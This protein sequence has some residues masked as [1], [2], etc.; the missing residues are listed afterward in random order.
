MK[1]TLGILALF[2]ALAAP[3][4]ALAQASGNPAYTYLDGRI[5]QYDPEGPGS[6][7]GIRIG[8]SY[9]F[10]QN[11]F[12][13]GSYT[14]VSDNG[15]DLSLLEFGAGMRSPLSSTM[16]LVGSAAVVL[17]D[18]DVD[19]DTGISLTGGVRAM[20]GPQFEVGGYAN[21]TEIFS[22][23]DISLIGEG[24]LHVTRELALVAS[25]SFSDDTDIV[26]LGARWNF[27]NPRR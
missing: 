21:Y 2:C 10:Q 8:G 9:L 25:L 20:V 18:T 23:G 7:D 14:T 6:L 4:P 11:L 24:L 1:N 3:L 17:A 26:T 19:D 27:R 22:D 16:D 15:F 12:G 13:F 5:V